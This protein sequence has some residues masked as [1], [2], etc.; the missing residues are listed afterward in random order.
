[1]IVPASFPDTLP[2]MAGLPDD[3]LATYKLPRDGQ[4]PTFVIQG[5]ASFRAHLPAEIRKRMPVVYF[6]PRGS[7]AV[8]DESRH[9]PLV[10]FTAEPD[11][12]GGALGI[13]RDAVEAGGIACFNHPA[14]VLDSTRDAVAMKLAGVPGLQVPR[15]I[16]VRPVQ[17]LDV[18]EAA[19]A[20]G[21]TWPVI[22]R[23]AGTHAGATTIRIDRREDVRDAMKRMPWGGHELYVTEYAAYSDADGMHRKMRLVV[24]GRD[25]FLRHVLA[26]P[27]WHVHARDHDARFDVEEREA[28]AAFDAGLLPRVRST[29]DALIEAMDL[30]YFGMDCS[31]R[32]DGR[33]LVF[34]ANANMNV[35]HD[36]RP[37]AAHCVHAIERIR[38]ALIALLADPARWRHP[39]RAARP[40]N[41]R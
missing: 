7:L 6:G 9:Q 36:S 31:L 28:M 5:T 1:M 18:A 33:L 38:D 35:L 8:S 16:R 2:V 10:N 15:T 30:D 23:V 24:V 12:C 40:A 41:A 11:T 34:E 32:P 39:G 22:V 3:N 27:G 20:A 21:L 25:V 37:D 29:L 14:A 4:S 17:P 26:T 13:L 19:E